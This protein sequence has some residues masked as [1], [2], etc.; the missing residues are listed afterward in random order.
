[1]KKLLLL[2]L[3]VFAFAVVIGTEEAVTEEA[4]P[5]DPLVVLEDE[6]F[7]DRVADLENPQLK[8][9]VEGTVRKD[10]L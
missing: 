10:Q 1:M 4:T 5:V 3:T 8:A 7:K 2:L 6:R 9:Y